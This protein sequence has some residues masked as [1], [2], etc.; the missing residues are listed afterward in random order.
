MKLSNFTLLLPNN[1]VNR[2]IRWFETTS[3]SIATWRKPKRS[4]LDTAFVSD[5]VRP[6]PLLPL[7]R[8]DSRQSITE[9]QSTEQVTWATSSCRRSCQE[10]FMLCMADNPS[11]IMPPIRWLPSWR[12]HPRSTLVSW[13]RQVGYSNKGCWTDCGLLPRFYSGNIRTCGT[14]STN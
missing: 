8:A 14:R 10:I 1:S 2:R 3:T 12:H 6:L 4:Q 7:R 9:T 5:D 13:T 11:T